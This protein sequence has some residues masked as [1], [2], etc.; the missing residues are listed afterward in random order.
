VTS[1]RSVSTSDPFAAHLRGDTVG[2]AIEAI[3]AG[4]SDWRDQEVH[5]AWLLRRGEVLASLDCATSP[6]A[7]AKGFAGRSEDVVAV[8]VEPSRAAHSI[9]LRRAIDVAYLDAARVVVKTTTLAPFRIALPPRGVRAVLEAE[10]GAFERWRL[11]AG[12]HL[13]VKE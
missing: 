2:E 7:R 11:C 10:A 1:S 8:L 12:D 13:D 5:M 3:A 4:T 9:G 6:L